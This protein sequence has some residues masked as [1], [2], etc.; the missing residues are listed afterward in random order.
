MFGSAFLD[1]NRR[2]WAQGEGIL[3]DPE[4]ITCHGLEE[5]Q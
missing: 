3:H 5:V 1:D 2:P 4:A